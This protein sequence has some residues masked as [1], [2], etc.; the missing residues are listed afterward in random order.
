MEEKLK[1]ALPKIK[2]HKSYNNIFNGKFILVNNLICCRKKYQSWTLA[3]YCYMI[4]LELL[5]III[6]LFC[7]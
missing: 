4:L 1:F 5:G 6:S 3:E 2:F 7:M